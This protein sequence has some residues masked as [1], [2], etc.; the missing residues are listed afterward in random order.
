MRLTHF[1]LIAAACGLV[2]TSVYAW[3]GRWV[4]FS[5]PPS[6]RRRAASFSLTRRRQHWQY[7]HLETR[8]IQCG[9]VETTEEFPIGST[10]KAGPTIQDTECATRYYDA[11]S[12]G[13]RGSAAPFMNKDSACFKE[14]MA[15]Y[16]SNNRTKVCK[17]TINHHQRRRAQVYQCYTATYTGAQYNK[18]DCL[19]SKQRGRTGNRTCT[20]AFNQAYQ[21]CDLI[22]FKA[23]QDLQQCFCNTTE[24]TPSGVCD[25][26]CEWKHI[27]NFHK[28]WPADRAAKKSDGYIQ[29]MIPDTIKASSNAKCSQTNVDAFTAQCYCEKFG[30]PCEKFCELAMFETMALHCWPGFKEPTIPKAYAQVRMPHVAPRDQPDDI[31]DNT[32]CYSRTCGPRED[33]DLVLTPATLS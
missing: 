17:N 29:M 12:C 4:H 9:K 20:D 21:D 16:A 23:K 26:F 27:Y 7:K 18:W 11:F 13:G 5:G 2:C 22:D 31:M 19:Q 8:N 15:Y 30:E 28:C 14:R 3:D 32:L 24:V 33:P 6:S 1:L 25:R 10:P